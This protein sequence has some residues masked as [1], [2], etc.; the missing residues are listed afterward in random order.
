MERTRIFPEMPDF[1]ADLAPDEWTAP[2]WQAASEHRL[3]APKCTVCGAFRMPPAPFCWNCRNQDVEW[4]ELSGRGTVFTFI[5]TRQP[6]IPQLKDAV[7]NV[8]AVIDLDGAPGCRLVS[9]VLQIDP[10]A[11]E[12]GLA[13][14]VAWD[15]IDDHATIPRF[16]PARDTAV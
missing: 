2:F 3:V 12:I 16:V 10:E 8:V 7:P 11:V 14:K 6:L 1:M 4:V 13:V 5:I 9:N 15:D